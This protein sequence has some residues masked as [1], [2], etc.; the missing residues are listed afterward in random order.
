MPAVRYIAGATPSIESTPFASGLVA[1]AAF[2]RILALR[3]DFNDELV[4]FR[5]GYP[6]LP[7]TNITTRLFTGAAMVTR[8]TRLR[9][10]R[11]Y[12]PPVLVQNRP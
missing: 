4:P 6:L 2:A 1:T 5:G 7:N 11:R 9:T 8:V 10:V 12:E 3:D